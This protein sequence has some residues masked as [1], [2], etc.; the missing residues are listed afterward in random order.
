MDSS[1]SVPKILVSIFLGIAGRHNARDFIALFV[2]K[3]ILELT[4]FCSRLI[5]HN[6]SEEAVYPVLN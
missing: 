5:C 6:T 2:P 1:A 3:P 4:F